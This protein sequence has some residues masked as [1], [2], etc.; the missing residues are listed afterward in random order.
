M[1]KT[2]DVTTYEGGVCVSL[3]GGRTWKQSNQGMDETAP[4]HILLD[5]TSPAGKR[6]LWVAAMGRGVYKSTDG[7]VTWTLKNNGIVQQKPLAWRLARA[8]DGTLYLVI[9]RYSWDGSIGTSQ[10]GAVYKSTDGADSWM[11]VNLPVGT[12]G[13]NGL[14]VDPQDSRRLYLAAWSRAVETGNNGGGI[15]LSTDGGSTWKIV[16]DR[17][18][19]IYDV[20]I[21]PR[22]ANILYAS[23]FESSAWRSNDRGEHWTRIPGYD[24]KMGHRVMPDLMDPTMIYISTFGG[25]VRHG[26]S[27]GA[28]GHADIATPI[29]QPGH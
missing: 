4:T 24:F 29:L 17:D 3:D 16:L 23:G 8:V 2:T 9:A 26:P 11:P 21:D 5:P 15:F 18:H 28:E 6:V 25:G 27:T 19:H 20:T 10:D 14:T 22:N 7:G 13:P 12:N 1:W